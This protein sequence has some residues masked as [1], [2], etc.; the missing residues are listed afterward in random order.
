MPV[1]SYVE[2]HIAIYSDTS[3]ARVKYRL[4]LND[5]KPVFCALVLEQ[6]AEMATY[7][8]HLSASEK[9]TDTNAAARVSI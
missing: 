6:R 7:H 5:T 2:P 1:E 4:A 3:H 8:E 9:H